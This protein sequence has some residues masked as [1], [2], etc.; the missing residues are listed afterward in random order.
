MSMDIN[1]NKH[2]FACTR[3]S[4]PPSARI[5]RIRISSRRVLATHQNLTEILA[6]TYTRIARSLCVHGK[7]H[8]IGVPE[9][10]YAP[11]C[12]L[13]GELEDATTFSR[14]R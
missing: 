13:E 9:Q 6:A 11:R 10:L 14:P 7:L 4:A 12:L 3:I 1:L 5:R 8:R 2:V